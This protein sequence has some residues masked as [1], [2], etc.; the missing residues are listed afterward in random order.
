[1]RFKEMVQDE[2]TLIL[3]C[4]QMYALDVLIVYTA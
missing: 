3:V 2:L 1:M 4:I